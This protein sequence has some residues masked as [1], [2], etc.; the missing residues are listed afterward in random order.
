MEKKYRNE[1]YTYHKICGNDTNLNQQQFIYWQKGEN[2]NEANTNLVYTTGFWYVR[3]QNIWNPNN[4][5][6][7]LEEENLKPYAD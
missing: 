6:G 7:F 4:V 1:V 3:T 2:P 5:T